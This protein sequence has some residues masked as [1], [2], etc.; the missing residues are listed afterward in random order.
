MK[1]FDTFG[2]SKKLRGAR[3]IILTG[4]QLIVKYARVIKPRAIK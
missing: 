2:V 1:E 4:I 3:N